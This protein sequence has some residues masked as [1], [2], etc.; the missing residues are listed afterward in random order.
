MQSPSSRVPCHARHVARGDHVA[1]GP[2]N[3]G[4]DH[5]TEPHRSLHTHRGQLA[6]DGHDLVFGNGRAGSHRQAR[7]NAAADADRGCDR[8]LRGRVLALY[9][10]ILMGGTP[11]GAPIV[12]WV[13]AEFGPRQAILLG[14]GAAIVAF[15]IGATWLVVSGR[16]HR[17]EERR[18]R[19]TIDETRPLSVVQPAPEEFSDEVASTTPSQVTIDMPPTC[20]NRTLPFV[21]PVGT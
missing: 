5:L 1:A 14:A 18:F 13:A 16:L 17:H 3:I 19:L 4:H 11:I 6:A 20:S 2:G 21:P 15:A 9:M 8:A 10:A 7:P 12:G